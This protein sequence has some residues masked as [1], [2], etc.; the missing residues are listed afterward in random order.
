MSLVHQSIILVL[1]P[2]AR[3]IP[4]VAEVKFKRSPVGG[5]VFYDIC[6]QVD[7][8]KSWGHRCCRRRVLKRSCGRLRL[9][10]ICRVKVAVVATR[11]WML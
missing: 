1:S 5:V 3:E 4:T 10:T 7:V 8:S 6:G 11:T 2:G 9:P